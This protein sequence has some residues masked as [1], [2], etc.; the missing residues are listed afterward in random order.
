MNKL[1][2]NLLTLGVIKSVEE[3]DIKHIKLLNALT[4]FSG[5][6]AL[7]YLAIEIRYF[8]MYTHWLII[9]LLIIS[10]SFFMVL[11]LNY[12]ARFLA[13][14]LLFNLSALV[15]ISFYVLALGSQVNG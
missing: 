6:F 11:W 14:R 15:F 1:W 12:Q 7:T 10:S 8:P 2:Q 3:L 9:C 13:A 4:T 5:F